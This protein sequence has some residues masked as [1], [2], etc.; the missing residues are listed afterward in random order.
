MKLFEPFLRTFVDSL[1]ALSNSS[2]AVRSRGALPEVWNFVTAFE[3]WDRVFDKVLKSI[4][5]KYSQ[6]CLCYDTNP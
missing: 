2:A 4:E 6:V 3:G 5:D 1:R